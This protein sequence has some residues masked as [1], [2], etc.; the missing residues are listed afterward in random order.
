MTASLNTPDGKLYIAVGGQ[1]Y[2]YDETVFSDDGAAIVTKWWMPWI[3]ANTGGKRWANK[4]IEVL[5]E[6]GEPLTIS[7]KRFKNYNNSSFVESNVTVHK[8]ENYWDIAD[9]D[10]A[11]WDYGASAPEQVRDHFIA[12]VLSYVVETNSTEGPLTVYGLKLFGIQGK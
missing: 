8:G 12:D 2:L 1:L 9:W 5:T 11:F 7:A 3:Q 4:Y 10:E 6:Q